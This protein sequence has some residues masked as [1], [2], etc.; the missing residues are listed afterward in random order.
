MH[1]AAHGNTAAEVI[2]QRIDGSKPNAGLT[3][4]KGNKPTKKETEIAKNYLNEQELEIL[5]R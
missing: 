5:N 3:T 2:Y 1:F 4:F